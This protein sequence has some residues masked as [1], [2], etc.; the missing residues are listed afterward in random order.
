[1][2][3]ELVLEETTLAETLKRAGYATACIGKWHLARR[4]RV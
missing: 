2:R 1:M 3:Q 4:Q